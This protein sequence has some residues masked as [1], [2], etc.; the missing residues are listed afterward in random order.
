MLS[1]ASTPRPAR[2]LQPGLGQVMRPV[3]HTAE[4]GIWRV[5]GDEQPSAADSGP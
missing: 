1:P 4:P 5:L 2:P 3:D